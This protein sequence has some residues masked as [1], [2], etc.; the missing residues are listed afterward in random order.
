M[1][2]RTGRS[3]IADAESGGDCRSVARGLREA[4]IRVLRRQGI[5]EPSTGGFVVHAA[6]G[7]LNDIR[8][9]IEAPCRSIPLI[10]GRTGCGS[11]CDPGLGRLMVP[12]L[13]AGAAGPERLRPLP[14]P[15]AGV[16]EAGTDET[17]HDGSATGSTAPDALAQAGSRQDP[18]AGSIARHAPRH[19][20]GVRPRDPTPFRPGPVRQAAS[21]TI[22]IQCSTH[23]GKALALP[24]AAAHSQPKMPRHA[25]FWRGSKPR[26]S[27]P[28][29]RPRATWGPP[30]I[31]RRMP[32]PWTRETAA[33]NHS[34]RH[35]A[36][37]RLPWKRPR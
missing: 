16:A 1:R 37:A 23:T 10:G 25:C 19:S 27:S 33:R 13:L 8:I 36:E 24:S 9:R 12:P 20:R 3:G 22:P 28:A 26:S 32:P 5:W 11:V 21:G 35:R 31:S 14:H 29:A 2:E 30:D 15:C 34:A 7:V 6:L 17:Q 18:R 4:H